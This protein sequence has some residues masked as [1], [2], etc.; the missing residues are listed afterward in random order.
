MERRN[1]TLLDMMRSMMNFAD[2]PMS[3]YGYILKTAAY[4]LNRVL[5][6][7]VASTPY[8]IWNDKRSNLKHVK[9]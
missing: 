3:F 9:I 6:K 1:H 2:L 4:L 5:T 7:S 8:E